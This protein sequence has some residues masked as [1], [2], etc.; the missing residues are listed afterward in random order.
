MKRGA[1]ILFLLAIALGCLAIYLHRADETDRPAGIID[2]GSAYPVSSTD[3]QIDFTEVV[4]REARSEDRRRKDEGIAI[5]PAGTSDPASPTAPPNIPALQGL[6]VSKKDGI[7]IGDAEVTAFLQGRPGATARTDSAARRLR[8]AL[9][10]GS[11]LRWFIDYFLHELAGRPW[12]RTA[13][14]VGAAHPH[15]GRS[16][17]PRTSLSAGGRATARSRGP[18]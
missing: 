3:Q 14:G 15:R 6:V 10:G 8:T 7:P 18:S 9:P 12:M 16:A 1:I 5:P 13:G 17:A 2:G 11:F 4:N